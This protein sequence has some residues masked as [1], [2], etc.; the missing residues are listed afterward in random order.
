VLRAEVEGFQLSPLG[1][2]TFNGV[3]LKP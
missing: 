2:H 3:S 1:R